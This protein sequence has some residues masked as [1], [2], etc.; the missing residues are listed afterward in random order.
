M[1]AR[2]DSNGGSGDAAAAQQ[3]PPPPPPPPPPR[4]QYPPTHRGVL[5]RS[6]RGCR[7]DVTFEEVVMSGLAPDRGLY[8]PQ[9]IPHIAP[10]QL[11]KV[12]LWVVVGVGWGGGVMCRVLF[13]SVCGPPDLTDNRRRGCRCQLGQVE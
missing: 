12:G 5:Y 3:P 2:A 9:E 8:V 6:T 11:D 4:P 13:G 10:E 7:R 1:A